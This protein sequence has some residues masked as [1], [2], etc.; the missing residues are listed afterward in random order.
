MAAGKIAF[1]SYFPFT[2]EGHLQL[3]ELITRYL[4]ASMSWLGLLLA[5]LGIAWSLHQRSKSFF[6]ALLSLTYLI[7][8]FWSARTAQLRYVMPAT[9]VLSFFAAYTLIRAWDSRARLLQYAAAA[10]AFSILAVSVLQGLDL[11]F[12]MLHDSRYAAAAWLAEHTQVGDRIEYFG[13]PDHLPAL[14]TGVITA[15]TPVNLDITTESS[16][17]QYS[18][19]EIK[20]GWVQRSPRYIII[21]PDLLSAPG[22]PY[23]G[24]CPPQIYDALEHG[25]L[26]Y[27]LVAYFQT[28]RLIPWL[29]EPELDYPVVNPPIRIFERTN[30]NL[31]S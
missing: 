6:F 13:Y 19:E 20:E 15:R 16:L 17:A 2:W 3:S 26:G 10:L 30:T 31:S 21:L 25:T 12:T 23:S 4:A 18:V 27:H 24:F 9:F 8:L 14:P 7:I 22:T 11:T 28:P 1:A 5:I 29:P